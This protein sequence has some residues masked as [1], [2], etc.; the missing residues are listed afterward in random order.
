MALLKKIQF[1]GLLL[2]G[3]SLVISSYIVYC[4]PYRV[5]SYLS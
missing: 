1:L 2:L 5:D 3:Y 4:T